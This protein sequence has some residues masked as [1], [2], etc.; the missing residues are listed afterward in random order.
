MELKKEVTVVAKEA[1]SREAGGRR[2]RQL[3]SCE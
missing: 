1:V 3:H 2:R